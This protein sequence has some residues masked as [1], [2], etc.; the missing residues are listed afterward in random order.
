M[1]G[2]SISTRL[3]FR[4]LISFPNRKLGS[5]VIYPN[6]TRLGHPVAVWVCPTANW[7]W[8]KRRKTSV[9]VSRGHSQGPVAAQFLPSGW[10]LLEF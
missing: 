4:F 10:Q 9:L 5:L 1:N 6:L 8:L 2:T 7:E 3:V